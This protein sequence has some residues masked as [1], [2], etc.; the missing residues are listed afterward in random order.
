MNS[1]VYQRRFAERWVW[2]WPAASLLCLLFKAGL[3]TDDTNSLRA[4]FVFALVGIATAGWAGLRLRSLPCAAA[5]AA[6]VGVF[7]LAAAVWGWPPLVG[8]ISRGASN[9]AF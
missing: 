5:L 8:W 9:A 1:V 4:L 3:W 7:V 2:C 6:S